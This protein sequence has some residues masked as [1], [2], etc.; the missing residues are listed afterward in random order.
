[1]IARD[2]ASLTDE[3]VLAAIGN[4]PISPITLLIDGRWRIVHLKL[5]G[6]NPFGSMKDRTALALITDLED[7]GRLSAESIII[8]S[9][10]GNLGVALAAIARVRRRR[11]V[12]VVD[13]KVTAENLSQ[14][15]RLNATV[16]MVDEAD[17]NGCYLTS[18]LRR[19]SD[20][21]AR[22]P[23]YVWTNQYA[24]PANPGIHY[25]TTGPEIGRQIPGPIDAVFIPVSTGGTLAGIGRYFQ[26]TRKATRIVAVD[27]QGSVVLG[28]RAHRRRLTGIGSDRRSSFILPSHYDE[29]VRVRDE[30]AFAACRMLA[31]ETGI[32]VGGSS[33]AALAACARYLRAHRDAR[34][35]VCVCPD[36]G[37]HY[38][39]TVFNDAW[40]SDQHLEPVSGSALPVTRIARTQW[41]PV[42]RTAP[43]S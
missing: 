6:A 37:S 4:T 36:D 32:K 1:M 14:I 18:R 7:R 8:E 20:M 25:A 31:R 16:E 35:V 23:H 21:C 10:S 9:T 2:A 17:A 28:G 43:S 11:F 3:R 33:G 41:P 29:H 12:A 24:N 42:L 26:Q 19:V 30:A 38:A 22:S 27:A 5:E 15:R 40:L 13:P 39:S 34:T